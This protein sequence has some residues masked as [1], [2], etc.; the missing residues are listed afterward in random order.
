[1]NL[2]PHFSFGI[3]SP[4]VNRVSERIKDAFYLTA[5]VSNWCEVLHSKGNHEYATWKLRNGSSFRAQSG[6]GD[7]LAARD[8]VLRNIYPLRESYGLVVDIGAQVGTFVARVSPIAERVVAFEPV[9]RNFNL[10]KDHCKTNKKN[11]EI[12]KLAITRDGRDV[13]LNLFEN[14]A[15]HSIYAHEPVLGQETV[16]SLASNEL[17]EFLGAD[18]IDLLKMDVEGAEYE[19][20]EHGADLLRAT[21]EVIMEA[22]E[23]GGHKLED[24]RRLL[25]SAGFNVSVTDRPLIGG[26]CVY[27]AIR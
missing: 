17:L 18:S 12:H 2:A 27:H 14:T 13:V 9:T 10:L 23:L 19:I 3:E 11:V 5:R 26:T 6:T 21:R 16:P 1:M 4:A 15:G 24:A 25:E 7:I 20:M 22:H 8:T